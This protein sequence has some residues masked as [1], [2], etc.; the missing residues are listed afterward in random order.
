MIHPLVERIPNMIY[1]GIMTGVLL[2]IL[3]PRAAEYDKV[4]K[5][6]RNVTLVGGVCLAGALAFIRY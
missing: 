2:E 5:K 3:L 1:A 4:Q 6:I